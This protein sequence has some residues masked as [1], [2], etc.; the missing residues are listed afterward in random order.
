LITA[1]VPKLAAVANKSPF[2]FTNLDIDS[3]T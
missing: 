1:C 2:K 3:A